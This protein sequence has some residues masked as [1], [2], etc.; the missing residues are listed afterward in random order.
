MDIMIKHYFKKFDAVVMLT[1]SDWKS[2][3]RSNRYHYAVRFSKYLPVIFVQPDLNNQDFYFEATEFDN[4][5]ILHINNRYIS[6]YRLNKLLEFFNKNKTINSLRSALKYLNIKSPIIWVYNPYFSN[7]IKTSRSHLKIYHASEDYFSETFFKNQKDKNLVQKNL[8]RTLKAIDLLISVSDGV[9]DNYISNG[10]YNGNKIVLENGCDFDFFSVP[11]DN[12][13]PRLLSNKRIVFYQGG[14]NDRIDFELLFV[15]V[16]KLPDWEFHFCG[17][18]STQNSI[19]KEIKKIDNFKYLGILQPEEIKN[20]AY[21]STIGIIPFLQEK[22]ITE[23]SLPLKAFEYVACGLPVVTIPIKSLR[24][25]E[26]IFHFAENSTEF[27]EKIIMCQSLR[28][29]PY[30]L[31][32]R[33]KIGNLKSYDQNFKKLL[34]VIG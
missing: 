20:F 2:E 11:P 21:Q 33:K 9:Q 6:R 14:I 3:P 32:L 30:H 5:T 28:L 7:Y 12:Y 22:H 23:S 26:D 31:E 4:I 18:I 25:Y 15:I 34:E 27:I 16:S 1:W 19:W 10:K 13:K 17:K 24:L 29:S 8:A